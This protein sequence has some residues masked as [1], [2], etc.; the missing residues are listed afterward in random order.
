MLPVYLRY[1]RAISRMLGGK[2]APL[3]FWREMIS[4]MRKV[5]RFHGAEDGGEGARRSSYLIFFEAGDQH[6]C[7]EIICDIITITEVV[8]AYSHNGVGGDCARRVWIIPIP[9][10]NRSL[11]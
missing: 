7:S 3:E 9:H 4:Q 10:L 11:P 5:V 1:C 6:W 2:L 8:V